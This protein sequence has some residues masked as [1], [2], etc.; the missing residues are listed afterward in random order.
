MNNP[1]LN[2]LALLVGRLLLALMFVLAGWQKIGGYAGTQKYMEGAGVPGALLPLVIL[3]ELGAGLALAA[4]FKT[5]YAA[6]ALAGF[7]VVATLLFHMN[8]GDRV[9]MLFFLKNLAV[10]GGLLAVFVAG[11]GAD[12]VDA[13]KGS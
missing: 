9:Q 2:N 12:S 3:T 7:T 8:L 6:L 4:G 10:T 13:K 11:A 1:A 5:R